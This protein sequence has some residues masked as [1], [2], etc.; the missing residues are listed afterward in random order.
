M[1]KKTD[2]MKNTPIDVSLDNSNLDNINEM[3]HEARDRMDGLTK[4][5]E[6]LDQ[7]ITYFLGTLLIVLSSLFGFGF[8][9]FLLAV[10]QKNFLSLALFLGFIL[11]LCALVFWLVFA[12]LPKQ[13]YIKG[14]EPLDFWENNWLTFSDKKMLIF[15]SERYQYMSE[16]MNKVIT[17]KARAL[18]WSIFL[19]ALLL[20]VSMISL[21]L[22]PFL[23]V[24]LLP[25][26]K[27]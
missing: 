9:T 1:H 3:I 14:L 21:F 15:L 18:K 25:Y 26:L 16:F 8:K 13:V 7:K 4:G 6:L 20:L 19:F 24:G 27:A 10:A 23:N 2:K 5:R 11:S 17:K 22:F 12:L